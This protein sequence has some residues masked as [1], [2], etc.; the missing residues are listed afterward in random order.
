MHSSSL[1][2]HNDPTLLFTNAGMN[3]F[4]DVFLGVDQRAYTRATTSQKCVRAGG[5]H[6]D[7]ENVGFTRRHHTFFEMLGNFSFGDYFKADA[8]AYAWELV[9]SPA[10]LG[11]PKDRL[12]V[13]IFAGENSS[14]LSVP[15]DTEAYDLWLAQGVPAERIFAMP[16]KDNFWQ[17][18][19]TGPCGPCSE[20]FYDLG[21]EAAEEPGVDKPF[22]QDDQRYV[23]IWNLVFM[24]FD[25]S[26]SASGEPTLAPLPKP[27]IDTGA[28]LERLAAVLQGKL[29]NYETDLF[30]PLIQ[31]AAALTGSRV[32]RRLRI[33]RRLSAHHRQIT[34]CD[35][36][37]S[38]IADGRQSRSN[39]GRGY[40]LRKIL[41]S[42]HPPRPPT[43]PNATV[44][45]TRWSSPFS[46]R[47]G[48]LPT[49]SFKQRRAHR[50][51][52]GG[53]RA[54]IRTLFT[55][56]GSEQDKN[57]QSNRA[58]GMRHGC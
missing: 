22:P 10:W 46:R 36:P 20:I 24:Q 47:D 9:T 26:L 15:R 56:A 5:K 29:S 38:F 55:K 2:P 17:M 53:R 12:Y 21:I 40:V 31:K 34:P 44:Y 30:V 48:Q 45:V 27:S 4:K 11:L 37:L 43:R 23:E 57:W 42:R 33:K 58:S 8:I 18:G 19:E 1:V 49:P 52:S 7:L 50:Q 28:G 25:R 32:R 39:E 3:Q 35:P 13:T 6:N 54:A 14:G 41:T 16:A 51:G